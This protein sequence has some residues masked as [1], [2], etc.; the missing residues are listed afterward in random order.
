MRRIFA[1][2]LCFAIP[3]TLIAKDNGYKV[4]YDGGSLPDTKSGSGVK[5]YIE[6]YRREPDPGSRRIRQT[7]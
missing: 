3:L 4:T 5:L 6:G 7:Y 1:V 2:L